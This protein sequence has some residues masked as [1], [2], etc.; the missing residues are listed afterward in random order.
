M[1]LLLFLTSLASSLRL[2]RLG[3]SRTF[4][5][6]INIHNSRRLAA[7]RGAMAPHS[8]FPGSTNK[9]EEVSSCWNPAIPSV[10][11]PAHVHIHTACTQHTCW[12]QYAYFCMKHMKIYWKN[13]GQRP[14]KSSTWWKLHPCECSILSCITKQTSMSKHN[15]KCSRLL[16]KTPDNLEKLLPHSAMIS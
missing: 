8:P 10:E 3:W 16:K 5:P 7:N 14:E 2:Y 4:H 6:N 12:F 1:P 15:K 9:T 13:T 11:A